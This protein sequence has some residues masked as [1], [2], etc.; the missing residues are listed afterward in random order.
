MKRLL[1]R[2]SGPIYQITKA[3]RQGEVGHLHNPEFS[4]LEWYRPG[5]SYLDLMDEVEALLRFVTDAPPALR[6]T[7]QEAFLQHTHLD[8]FQC[9]VFDLQKVLEARQLEI[10]RGL[11]TDEEGP[12]LDWVLAEC[13]EPQFQNG[14]PV[15]LTEYPPGR[16]A[17]ARH[18]PGNP[19]VEERFELYWKGVEIANGFQELTDPVEQRKRFEAINR[20]RQ[21]AG[22][23]PLA[24]DQKFLEELGGMPETSGVAIGLDRL[25]MAAL[26]LPSIHGAM[27]FP[28][29]DL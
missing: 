15:F 21:K 8:P 24:L 22:F 23:E 11:P 9:S 2:G 4:I 5:Y 17:L 28:F 1:A 7:F 19:T 14:P 16:A 20:K 26:D 3:F 29:H 6:I 18:R 27:S 12:W 10:P 13:I 25:V